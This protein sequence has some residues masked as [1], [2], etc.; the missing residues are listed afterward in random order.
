MYSIFSS[1]LFV[2]TTVI[3]V[4]LRQNHLYLDPGSGSF[5]LQLIL[6]SLL[7]ALFFIRVYWKKIKTFFRD[8]LTKRRDANE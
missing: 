5:I 2:L 6:A 3:S 1:T 8:R 7:G 4:P